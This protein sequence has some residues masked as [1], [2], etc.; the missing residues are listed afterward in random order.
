MRLA[1]ATNRSRAAPP[2]DSH[3]PFRRNRYR[4]L[5][6]W[7]IANDDH[8]LALVGRSIAPS[9]VV[10]NGNSKAIGASALLAAVAE[11]EIEN[12]HGR[13]QMMETLEHPVA[14]LD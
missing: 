7:S 6:P 9:P 5:I 1:I 13:R 8:P 10:P 12:Q 2:S 14:V 4:V 3:N 11:L